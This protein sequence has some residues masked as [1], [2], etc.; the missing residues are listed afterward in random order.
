MNHRDAT[1][2]GG[3]TSSSASSSS[4]ALSS[5]KSTTGRLLN[6]TVPKEVSRVPPEK[7]FEKKP[8]TATATSLS[9]D[10]SEDSD[11]KSEDSDDDGLPTEKLSMRVENGK[12]SAC[13]HFSL[14]PSM[15]GTLVGYDEVCEE[16]LLRVG[17]LVIT[18]TTYQP[19]DSKCAWVIYYMGP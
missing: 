19:S 8:M 16:K 9:D 3:S 1:N 13:S 18:Q 11:D 17:L 7:S 2:G 6:G 4:S 10:K 14:G 15:A 5:S 12:V